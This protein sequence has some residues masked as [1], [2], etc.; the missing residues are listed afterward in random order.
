MRE[1]FILSIALGFA[2]TT[3]V[4]A[5]SL[6]KGGLR[7]FDLQ[8]MHDRANFAKATALA[9]PLSVVRMSSPPS[10]RTD[11]LSRNDE[12]CNYGCIDH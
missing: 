1:A 12:D 6:E 4:A 5:N 8:T 3:P 11:G 2:L 10:P 9:M 7:A